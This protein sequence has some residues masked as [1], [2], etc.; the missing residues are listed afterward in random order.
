MPN[1]GYCRFYNTVGDL[2][3]CLEHL[4]DELSP[5]ENRARKRLILTAWEIVQ[6]FLDD[7]GQLDPEMID[8]LPKES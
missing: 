2:E 8:E 7:D 5:E 4:E 6:T 1:M 3:D